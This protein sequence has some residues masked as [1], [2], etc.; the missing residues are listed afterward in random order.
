MTALAGDR[1]TPERSGDLRVFPAAAS[2]V[3]FAGAMGAVN[4]SGQAVPMS[5]ALNLKGAGRV[6]RRVDNTGGAAGAKSVEIY[7]G[8]FRFDNST[9]GDAITKADIGSDCY[10]VDDQ[11]VAKTSATNTRSVAGK[12]FDVDADGVWVKFS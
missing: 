6:E 7:A 4:A 3:L 9:A 11:T 5:T 2:A 1:R 8:I 12:V 10:G